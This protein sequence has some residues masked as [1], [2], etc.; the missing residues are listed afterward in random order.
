[1]FEFTHVIDIRNDRISYNGVFSS[2]ACIMN[3]YNVDSK[4]IDRT[5]I[6]DESIEN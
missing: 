4:V 6:I 2:V 1:M 3:R 5:I